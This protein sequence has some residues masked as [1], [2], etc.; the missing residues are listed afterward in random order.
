MFSGK[1]EREGERKSRSSLE[2]SGLSA[3]I[4]VWDSRPTTLAATPAGAEQGERR[5]QD[6]RSQPGISSLSAPHPHRL[7][8]SQQTGRKRALGDAALPKHAAAGAQR[9][10]RPPGL[11]HE[12]PCGSR[13]RE[14][15][16]E[17]CFLTQVDTDTPPESPKR[18]QDCL[19]WRKEAFGHL[20]PP[21]T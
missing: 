16:A 9:T 20:Q 14:V 12:A 7:C 15:V 8:T 5:Q 19:T 2:N 21:V 4:R 1:E 10:R 13:E 17:R 18:L 3:R 11:A 6:S